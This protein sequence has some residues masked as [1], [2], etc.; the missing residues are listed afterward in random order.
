MGVFSVEKE[1]LMV[2]NIDRAELL[3]IIEDEDAQVVDVLPD[4]EYS[5][6]HIPGA[7]NIPLKLLDATTTS[8][9]SRDKPVVVY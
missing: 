1:G 9:L 3:R 6:A 8:V 2:T 7:V 4:E 5:S